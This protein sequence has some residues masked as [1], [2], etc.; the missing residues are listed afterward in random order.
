MEKT[1]WLHNKK[2]NPAYVNTQT[3]QIGNKFTIDN[4]KLSSIKYE[5]GK[6]NNIQDNEITDIAIT[7]DTP[8]LSFKVNAGTAQSVSLDSVYTYTDDTE[9]S[10]D[11]LGTCCSFILSSTNKYTDPMDNR[12]KPIGLS[13]GYN[14]TGAQYPIY[15]YIGNLIDS[16]TFDTMIG[17]LSTALTVNTKFNLGT[18][19]VNSVAPVYILISKLFG[20]K[21]TSKLQLSEGGIQWSDM[22]YVKTLERTYTSGITEDYV[23]FKSVNNFNKGTFN[24][25]YVQVTSK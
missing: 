7:P 9:V 14:I 13:G 12:E 8:N 2:D 4:I 16:Y 5:V 11:K 3:Y 24:N 21:P 6:Y 19:T 23:V 18:F 17:N 25:W 20:V 15:R 1:A 10:I 22:E